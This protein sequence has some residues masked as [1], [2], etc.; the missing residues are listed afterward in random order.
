MRSTARWMI[1]LLLLGGV[2]LAAGCGGGGAEIEPGTNAR[3]L[4]YVGVSGERA[5]RCNEDSNCTE[6]E[7]EFCWFADGAPEGDPGH[8]HQ[9]LDDGGCLGGAQCDHGACHATCGSSDDC[10][11]PARCT[12]GFCRPPAYNL[13]FQLSSTGDKDL[14][15]DTDRT[16]VRGG[17][18]ACAFSRVEWSV[19][20]T[21]G[22]L[23][24]A[25]DDDVMVRVLFTPPAVGEYKAVIQIYSNAENHSPLNLYPCGRALE[26][27]CEP[28][29]NGMDSVCPECV[30]CLDDDF[31]GLEAQ[32]PDCAAYD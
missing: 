17:D 11:S 32:T 18:D 2:A 22:T 19:A 13:D 29:P 28:P 6:A 20:P 27:T 4:C 31:A 25:P 21:D 7:G 23:T 26:E 16:A 24:V 9:C 30:P 5:G 1:G 15:I 3:L 12:G 10:V 14:V 8:C